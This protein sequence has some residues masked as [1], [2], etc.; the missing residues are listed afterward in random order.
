MKNLFTGYRAN[1]EQPTDSSRRNM[2]IGLSVCSTIIKAHGS[3]IR[4]KN[5]PNGGAEF[6]FA[7]EME[8][9]NHGE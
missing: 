9:T 3:E 4:V 7:L 5:R 8:V 6:S 1:E 2:G